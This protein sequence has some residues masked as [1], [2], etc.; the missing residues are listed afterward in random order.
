M[1]LFVYS[2]SA[3]GGLVYS[4]G[5]TRYTERKTARTVSR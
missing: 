5:L 2:R 4:L 3:G 1:S